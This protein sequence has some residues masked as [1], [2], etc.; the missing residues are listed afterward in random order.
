MLLLNNL[1]ALRVTR[2]ITTNQLA[3]LT[4]IDLKRLRQLEYRGHKTEPWFDEAFLIHRVLGTQ[5]IMPLI[6]SDYLTDKELGPDMA[7]DLEVFRSGARLP[8]DIACRVAR[9]LHLSDPADLYVTQHA[10][11]MWSVLGAGERGGAPAGH[12][13]WC[14]EPTAAGKP[15]ALTCLPD[16]LWGERSKVLV[17]TLPAQPKPAEKGKMRGSL[18]AR[19]LKPMREKLGLSQREMGLKLGTNG[20]TVARIERL[21]FPL[22][23]TMAEKWAKQS[24]IN[25]NLFYVPDPSWNK[26]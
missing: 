15:H 3:K 12:C 22:T 23:R 5:G 2:D 4:G 16:M 19:G 24:G 17:P 10:R 25:V 11:F 26:P 6:T 21:D 20:N 18:P 8:I 13:P 9:Q 7:Y 1:N 14:W